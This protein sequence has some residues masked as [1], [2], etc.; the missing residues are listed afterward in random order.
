MVK[1]AKSVAVATAAAVVD[2]IKRQRIGKRAQL[3]L[4]VEKIM[5]ELR[6]HAAKYRLKRWTGLVLTAIAEFFVNRI[7]DDSN[8]LSKS[9]L[10]KAKHL[11][12]SLH[13]QTQ[14]YS[15]FFGSDVGG[16]HTIQEANEQ[17]A[18]VAE[19]SDEHNSL[20]DEEENDE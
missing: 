11:H 7:L 2:N 18:V 5:K 12:Q 15:F 9:K 14:T 19:G 13:S 8:V 16:I 10:I 1:S 6:K 17:E 3:S 20:E 4:P